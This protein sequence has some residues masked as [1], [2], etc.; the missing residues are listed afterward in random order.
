MAAYRLEH[1]RILFPCVPSRPEHPA[2]I[3]IILEWRRK[4]LQDKAMQRQTSTTQHVD[5]R[6]AK[7]S[8]T[9]KAEHGFR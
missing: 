8:Q 2:L 4:A 6:D 5:V 3:I 1:L 7:H 9:G